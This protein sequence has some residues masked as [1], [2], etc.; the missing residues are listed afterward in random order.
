[1]GY[2]YP[3]QG[4]LAVSILARAVRP[5]PNGQFEKLAVGLSGAVR[6]LPGAVRPLPGAV[7]PPWVERAQKPFSLLTSTPT[8][9]EVA[10]DGLEVC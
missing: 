4:K 7:R 1:M 2:L 5:R 3:S 6:P 9:I 8:R 10:K